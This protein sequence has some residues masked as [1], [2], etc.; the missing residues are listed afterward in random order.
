MKYVWHS[1]DYSRLKKGKSARVGRLIATLVA[2][3]EGLHNNLRVGMSRGE[4]FVLSV[5]KDIE[6]ERSL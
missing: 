5:R 4:Q 6:G 2:I 1:G 3:V